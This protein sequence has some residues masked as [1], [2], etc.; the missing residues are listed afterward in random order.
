MGLA[1]EGVH[2]DDFLALSTD[3]AELRIRT[4]IV[5]AA[6][7]MGDMLTAVEYGGAPIGHGQQVPAERSANLSIVSRI[8]G[9]LRRN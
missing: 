3:F 1:A 9:R 4:N 2:L 8:L 7:C 5:I 6:Y